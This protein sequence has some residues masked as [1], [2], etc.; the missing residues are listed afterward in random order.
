MTK[1]RVLQ[2]VLAL[3]LLLLGVAAGRLWDKTG[4]DLVL[5]QPAA[6]EELPGFVPGFDPGLAGPG[7]AKRDG[8]E[9]L[10]GADA[11]EAVVAAVYDGDTMELADGQAVRLIGIDSPERGRPFYKE[12]RE[13][14]EQLVLGK[15]VRLEKD[16]SETDRYGRL[17]RYIYVGDA[18]VNRAMVEQGYAVAM[19]YPPDVRHAE[20]FAQA[21]AVARSAG[22][23]F[24][25][26]S[27][28]TSPRAG[29]PVE[30]K[31]KTAPPG[32]FTLPSCAAGDCDCG[33][34]TTHAHAQWFH[35]NYNSG[36]AHRLDRDKDSLACESLP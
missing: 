27:L 12:A 14:L 32:G 1:K 5:P 4:A 36:D 29:Q 21:E 23:G 9:A 18:F 10:F 26:A 28:E 3:T 33:H 19:R 8:E 22:K 6:L 35:E 34:F 20:T 2:G 7:P 11:E 17:L 15:S 31:E 16:V 24:W 25:S 30:P 13:A